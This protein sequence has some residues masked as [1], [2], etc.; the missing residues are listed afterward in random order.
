MTNWRIRVTGEQVDLAELPRLL[1][2]PRA[3]VVQAG[4]DF[5]L[6]STDFDDLTEPAAVRAAAEELVAR[7]SG[8]LRLYTQTECRL[9]VDQVQRQ[10]PD[11]TWQGFV[12][13]TGNASGRASAHA[14][15]SGGVEPPP[16]PSTVDR[17]L[18]LA[19]S[20]RHGAKVLRLY[21]PG[22]TLI[23]ENLYRLYEVI[24]GAMGGTYKGQAAI[25]SA[26]WASEDDIKSFKYTAN[27]VNAVGDLA[28]HGVEPLKYNKP[29]VT[30]P[31]QMPLTEAQQLVD[32]IVREWLRSKGAI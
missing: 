26:G 6:L 24:E 13:L 12:E 5:F 22:H 3:V 4:A 8:A 29:G 16:G 19:A 1:T 10:Q 2:D 20:D 30:P 11:G 31:R 21:H 23:W 17:Q 9:T 28:R 14:S 32:R 25:V 7:V 27:S 15:L 18:T